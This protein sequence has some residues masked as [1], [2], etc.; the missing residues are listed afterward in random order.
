MTYLR[1]EG[2]NTVFVWATSYDQ[3]SWV[4]AGDTMTITEPGVVVAGLSGTEPVVIFGDG[5]LKV[6]KL[7]AD[8]L[9]EADRYVVVSPRT[10]Y[11]DNSSLRPLLAINDQQGIFVL[12]DCSYRI[13][14]EYVLLQLGGLLLDPAKPQVVRWRSETPLFAE[15]FKQTGDLAPVGAVARGH[16]LHVYWEFADTQLVSVALP[17]PL[18]PPR[19][20]K[21]KTLDLIQRH[22]RNP[23]LA[24]SA[25]NDWEAAG[26]FNP[27]A[28]AIDGTV[29][30]IFR[31]VGRDGRSMFGYAASADGKTIDERS[32]KPVYWPRAPFEGIRGKPSP[33]YG[34]WQSGWGW[35]GCEDPKLTRIGNRVYMTYVA[36]DGASPPRSVMT[37]IDVEDFV[38]KNWQWDE[39][40]LISPPGVVTKSACLLEEM[41]DGKYVMFHR[42]FPNILIDYLDDL[43]FEGEDCWLEGHNHI[44]IRPTMWDSRKLSIGAPPIKT[45]FGWLVVYHAVDDRDDTRYKIGAM[46]LA[47]D[48]PAQVLWR[49]R[50]PILSPDM[51]YENNWKPGIAYPSGAVVKDGEL[52]IYYGGGDMTV[53]LAQAN[54]ETF[55]RQLMTNEHVVEGV[56]GTG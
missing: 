56:P 12:Y 47:L 43:S 40:K 55:M 51:W 36:H 27:A 5:L 3:R 41:V 8:G 4:T 24:P 20:R 48:N 44:P 39:P 30:L 11:F 34:T 16:G 17:N 31:A 18:R 54:M 33:Y 52:L 7:R 35:G 49:T 23:I 21:L 37:A 29:H 2:T 15:Q 28:V 9:R 6:T 46:I 1:G 13:N 10:G 42:I 50:Y 32:S 14:E 53:C 22:E 38:N 25:G 19:V 26:T 45:E